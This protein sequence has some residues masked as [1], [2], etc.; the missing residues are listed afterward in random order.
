MA[1]RIAVSAYYQRPGRNFSLQERFISGN[2][3]AT[4]FS[5]RFAANTFFNLVGRFWSFLVALLLTPYVLSRLG[6]EDF[7]VWILLSVFASSFGLLDVGLGWSFIKYVSEYRAVGE[8]DRINRVL[9]AGVAFYVLLGA[10]FLALG[11]LLGPVL[12]RVFRVEAE[13]GIF[14]LILGA[15]GVNN[16]ALLMLSMLRGLQRMDLSNAVEILVTLP[17]VAGTILVLEAG[18]GI[19]GLAINALLVAFLAGTSGWVCLRRAVPWIELRWTPDFALLGRL[20]GYGGKLQVVR[21]SEL[22]CFQVDRLIVSRFL[23]V[24]SVSFY[25]LG[26]RLVLF[27]RALPYVLISVVTPA[28]SELAA[29]D[30]R[31][32]A[33]RMYRLA[34]KYVGAATVGLVALV[35]LDATALLVLWLGPGFEGSAIIV[36]ILAV[37]YGVNAMSAVAG[38]TGS[39]FGRPDFEMRGAILLTVVNPV[40]SILLIQALGVSGVAL[41]T[42]LALGAGALYVVGVFHASQAGGS[43][44]AF[45]RQVY[46][47]PMIAALA[48][49]VCH[50]GLTGLVPTLAGGFGSRAAALARISIATPAFLIVYVAVLVVLGHLKAADRDNLR[51]LSGFVTDTIRR[52]MPSGKLPANPEE[53]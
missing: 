22:V 45:L 24:A 28:V 36:R 48:G 19:R 47:R 11:G 16:L 34:S 15:F 14:L 35:M 18:M 50:E 20:L 46:M 44:G 29:L 17:R 26:S 23:D 13:P 4:D 7:G 33:L 53:R 39:G 51:R 41:G 30:D 21:L 40:L 42:S 2:P 25:E 31:A 3:D 43:A 6:V 49:A 1:T 9:F 37:G 52:R 38:Q 5:R 32:R 8:F 10:G 27:M 12:F